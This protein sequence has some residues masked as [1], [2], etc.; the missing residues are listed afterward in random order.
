LLLGTGMTEIQ[1]EISRLQALI[2]EASD[3]L[4]STGLRAKPNSGSGNSG[5]APAPTRLRR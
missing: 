3:L 5:S 2:E 1:A 4:Q